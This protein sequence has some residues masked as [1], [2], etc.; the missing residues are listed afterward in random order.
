MDVAEHHASS[1]VCV[2]VCVVQQW[3]RTLNFGHFDDFLMNEFMTCNF[4]HIVSNHF[5]QTHTELQYCQFSS[6]LH[7]SNSRFFILIQ[8]LVPQTSHRH[9]NSINVRKRHC[10]PKTIC[11]YAHFITTSCTVLKY[12]GVCFILDSLYFSSTTTLVDAPTKR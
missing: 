8:P 12:N 3:I 10:H 5:A 1:W 11:A 2:C 9:K 6:N 7:V 4:L